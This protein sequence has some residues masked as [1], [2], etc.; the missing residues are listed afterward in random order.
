MWRALGLAGPDST[1][2]ATL[3]MLIAELSPV[4]YSTTD[5]QVYTDSSFTRS[6][7]ELL[8]SRAMATAALDQEHAF[9]VD[10]PSRTLDD[11]A[12]VGA[13]VRQQSEIVADDVTDRPPPPT[14][15][16]APLAFLPAVLDY[17]LTAPVVFADLLPPVD[18]VAAN[19][20]AGIGPQGPGPL[21][22]APLTPIPS[23][24]VTAGD[25][26][27][28]APIV[29]DRSLWYLSFASHLDA[30]T[31][32]RMSNDL[33][34]A[35]LQMV[36]GPS[37]RCAVATF[38]TA[39]AA[40][41]AALQTD[42]TTWVAAT[43]PALGAS[44]TTLPDSSVQLRSCDPVADF[45]SNIRFGVARELIAWR[46]VELGVTTNVTTQGGDAAAVATA[47]SDVASSPAALA[48]VQL[49]AGTPPA[50]L[51]EAARTAATDVIVAGTLPAAAGES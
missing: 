15:D 46:A 29:T 8:V 22:V 26:A 1:D 3:Q 44:A 51:A 28:G 50:E 41:N 42:L 5:G 30:V 14:V 12:L 48:V 43:S 13:H 20:L 7:R 40:T 35:G 19:P 18:D 27:V 6:D 34:G 38:A 16:M 33:Q 23:E 47:V 21:T 36:D 24:S 25:A 10:A 9:S 2:D 31:A 45:E 4:L 37:G 11:A 39:D 32:Y 49:P 17:R